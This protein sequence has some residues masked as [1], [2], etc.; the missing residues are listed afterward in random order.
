MAILEHLLCTNHFIDMTA[1]GTTLK[2]KCDLYFIGEKAEA[3]KK[4]D[5]HQGVAGALFLFP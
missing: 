2:E 4:G 3:L 1:L 5:S